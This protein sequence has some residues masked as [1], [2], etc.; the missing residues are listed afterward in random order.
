VFF[1]EINALVQGFHVYELFLSVLETGTYLRN[2]QLFKLKPCTWL[3]AGT[4]GLISARE[5]RNLLK[6]EKQRGDYFSSKAPDFHSRL[7]IKAV[8][9]DSERS[10]KEPEP[11]EQVRRGFVYH[12]ALQLQKRH[13]D[14]K[15]IS[16]DV[17]QAFHSLQDDTSI[18]EIVQ[19]ADRFSDIPYGEVKSRNMPREL[20]LKLDPNQLLWKKLRG[21]IHHPEQLVEVHLKP[22]GLPDIQT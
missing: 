12:G 20:R 7:T 13:S 2:G 21:A 10:E 6:D 8:E 14:I 18:R 16:L 4:D 22:S 1:D 19:F 11:E 5:A 15:K 9:L 17:L 3:F